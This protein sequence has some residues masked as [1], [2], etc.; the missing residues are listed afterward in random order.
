MSAATKTTRDHAVIQDWVEKRGGKP[1]V[2]KGTEDL[3]R[4]DFPG[5]EGGE[6]LQEITWEEFFRIFNQNNLTLLYQEKTIEGEMSRFNKFVD[7][8]SVKN[9]A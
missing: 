5:F 6:S 9:S 8:S 1:A 2:V 4:I 3:L 7:S